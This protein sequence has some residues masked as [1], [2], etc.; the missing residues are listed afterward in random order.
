[1]HFIVADKRERQWNMHFGGIS[2]LGE[3]SVRSEDAGVLETAA[4]SRPESSSCDNLV[5]VGSAVV[6]A[7]DGCSCGKVALSEND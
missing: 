6:V 4:E 7:S 1:M 3:Q 5:V 2:G